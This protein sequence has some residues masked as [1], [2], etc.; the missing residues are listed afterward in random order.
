M[1]PTIVCDNAKEMVQGELNRK[2]KEA[3]CHLWQ[4]ELFIPWLNPAEREIKELK[5]FLEGR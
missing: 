2:F 1:L 5:K 3:A 4:T